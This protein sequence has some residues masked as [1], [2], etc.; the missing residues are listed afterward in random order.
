MKFFYAIQ[1]AAH[2]NSIDQQKREIKLK[3]QIT[4]FKD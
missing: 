4:M 2:N 3:K 1:P